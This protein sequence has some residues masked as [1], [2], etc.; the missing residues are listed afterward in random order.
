MDVCTYSSE[1]QLDQ[2]R[3][4]N[5]EMK[6][7]IKQFTSDQVLIDFLISRLADKII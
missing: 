3:K 5:G 6:D 4:S 7:K 2:E 1:K